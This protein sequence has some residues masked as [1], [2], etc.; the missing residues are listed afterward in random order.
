MKDR[1]RGVAAWEVLTELHGREDVLALV[2]LRELA[3]VGSHGPHPLLP[4]HKLVRR[5]ALHEILIHRVRLR[6]VHVEGAMRLPRPEKKLPTPPFC[7]VG[8]LAWRRLSEV[9]EFCAAPGARRILSVVTSGL[10]SR[11]YVPLGL[12]ASTLAG[13][14]PPCEAL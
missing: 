6:S 10:Q 9:P 4:V 2:H 5:A 13:P 7:V 12:A 3:V 14:Q 11:L 8:A 1:A